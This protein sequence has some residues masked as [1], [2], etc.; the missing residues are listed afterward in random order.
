MSPLRHLQGT[1]SD[2]KR[3]GTYL[4]VRIQIG[5]S[6]AKGLGARVGI[7]GIKKVCSGGGPAGSVCVRGE[8]DMVENCSDL[9]GPEQWACRH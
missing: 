3:H 4:N 2:G 7:S 9:C 1:F 6:R 5:H 8:P